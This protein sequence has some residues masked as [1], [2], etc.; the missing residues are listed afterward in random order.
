MQRNLPL[1][2]THRPQSWDQVVG[3]TAAMKKINVLRQRGLGGRV[4]FI[5]G[6][7]GVGKTTIARLIAKELTLPYAIYEMDAQRMSLADVWEFDRMCHCKPLGGSYH[8]WIINEAHNMSSKVV[9]EL[10]TVLE[11]PHV[12][13]NSTWAF[14][15]TSRGEKLLFDSKFDAVPFLSRAIKIELDGRGSEI[16]FALRAREIAQ[17]EGL[18]GKPLDDY[19]KLLR[20]CSWNLRSILN[21]IESG[22]FL[23]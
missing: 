23:E 7:S 19:L 6:P 21:A 2:E 20:D 22:E 4:F 1:Y 13:R 8:V 12:Q 17:A 16:D 15:T 10:Q 11:S 14:T 5:T 9:S 18:D 3:Q